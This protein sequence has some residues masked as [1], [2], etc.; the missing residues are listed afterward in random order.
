MARLYA[1]ED[2][3]Y[4]AVQRLRQLGHDVV[5]AEE[6]GHANQRTTDDA[7]LAFAAADGR[8]VVSFKRRHFVRLHGVVSSHGGI[9]VCSRDPDVSAL[10]ARIH[11]ALAEH[12]T[13]EDKLI[14][15]YRPQRP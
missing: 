12:A 8:A 6:A 9:V 11:E 4:P 1:D 5:T 10:A 3:S 2:F 7:I 15:V 14:R 13:L